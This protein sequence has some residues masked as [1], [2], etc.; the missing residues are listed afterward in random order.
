[1]PGQERAVSP[2]AS[3]IE[4]L[5]Q[6]VKG[7]VIQSVEPRVQAFSRS[8]LLM[9]PGLDDP[10]VLQHDDAVGVP[11]RGE[12]MGDNDAGTAL[13]QCAPRPIWICRSV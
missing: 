7:S 5:R 8:Q 2:T 1:M 3:L 9:C 10:A 6:I 11:H 12:P 13:Q 4:I